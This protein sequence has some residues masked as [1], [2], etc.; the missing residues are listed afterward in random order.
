M[1]WEK[2]KNQH[3]TLNAASAFS[4]KLTQKAKHCR[5]Q[6]RVW[7]RRAL[8][9]CLASGLGLLGMLVFASAASAHADVVDGVVTCA[10]PLGTGYEI[11]WSVANDYNLSETA[12]VSAATGGTSTVTPLSFDISA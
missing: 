5:N 3:S 10:S 8:R 12:H 7:P 11:H 2:M 1:N 6:A 9:V 4:G